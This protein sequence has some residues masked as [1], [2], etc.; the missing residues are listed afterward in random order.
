MSCRSIPQTITSS[1]TPVQ[2]G[3]LQRECTS[4]GQHTIAGGECAECT[5]KK[6]GLQRKLAIGASN[7]PLEREADRVADQVM[8]APAHPAV[9]GALPCIQRYAEGTDTAPAS[10]DHVLTSSGKPLETALQQDMEKRFGQDFSRVRVHTGAAAEQSARDVSAHAYTVGHNMVF[11]AGQFAPGTKEGRRLIAHEL[12]HVMQQ[13]GASTYTLQRAETDTSKNCQPLADTKSDVNAKINKSLKD[14][15]KTVG[16]P[17]NAEKVIDEVANDLATN[18]SPGR[19]AIEDWASTLGSKK[20]DLP[21]QSATK[22]KGVSFVLWRQPFFKILNPTMKVNGICIGSDKLGHFIELGFRYYEMA[23]RTSGGKAAAAEEFGERT[24]G[25]DFGLASTGVFSNA[26]LEANRQ[27]L[28]FYDD[29][30]ANPSLTF[31]IANYISSK[32]NEEANP[33][34]YESSVAEQVWS[35]LLTRPW[36]GTFD[37]EGSAK[38][39]TVNLQATTAGVVTGSYDYVGNSGPI[40]GKI[41]DG[42]LKFV[43][44]TVKADPPPSTATPVAGVEIEFKWSEDAGRGL[45]K[46][47]STDE[48]HLVGTWGTGSSMTNGG[49]WNIS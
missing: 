39:V 18:T 49:K 6:S 1:F 22:Y 16:T 12:T 44:K 33:N 31:D 10:V 20:V 19:A 27:G 3:L 43:T 47:T 13:G 2:A 26:D 45:G 29:V 34:F 4:C 8:A 15:R 5:K 24:E 37:M 11:G 41:T 32:W 14:A 25:G 48:S 30:K 23:R 21:K 36:K 17:L 46:W 28:K 40:K 7:D 35:N 42:K 9:S 38:A